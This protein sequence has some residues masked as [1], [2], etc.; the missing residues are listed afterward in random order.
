MTGE[1]GI[2]PR[3]HQTSP[4]SVKHL[5]PRAAMMGWIAVFATLPG[6]FNPDTVSA[7]ETANGKPRAYLRQSVVRRS[8]WAESSVPAGACTR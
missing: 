1:G 4:R 7:Y 6:K 3:R 5:L 2:L 8:K